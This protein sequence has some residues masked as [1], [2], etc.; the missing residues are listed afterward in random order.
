MEVLE[1]QNRYFVLGTG[2]VSQFCIYSGLATSSQIIISVCDAHTHIRA[3][4]SSCAGSE[5][6]D[7]LV[8]VSDVVLKPRIII[9]NLKVIF[10]LTGIIVL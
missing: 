1:K 3:E 9:S 6:G 5:V 4:H 10:K 2:C 8:D 7:A